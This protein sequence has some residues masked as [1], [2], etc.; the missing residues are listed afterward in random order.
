MNRSR[1][2]PVLHSPRSRVFAALLS[3]LWLAVSLSCASAQEYDAGLRLGTEWFQWEE[4]SRSGDSLLTEEGPRFTVG[5]YWGNELKVQQGAYYLGEADLYLGRVDYDGETIE[6]GEAVNTETDYLGLR[7]EFW[8]GY[9]FSG[10]GAEGMSFDLM[11]SLGMDRW[12]RSLADSRLDDGTQVVGYD[13]VYTILYGRIGAGLFA[14]SGD[15]RGRLF[16]GLKRPLLTDE[17]A[18]LSEIG[19]SNDLN[20]EPEGRNSWFVGFDNRFALDS[21]REMRLNLYYDSYRFDES[22]YDISTCP[23]SPPGAYVQPES[24][25]DTIGVELGLTF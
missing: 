13:E 9:R 21:G 8:A 20:L 7:G 1:H 17:V 16:G 25:M 24:H 6:S 22:D 12:L 15:W 18:E 19:C 4:F 10:P 11:G 3:G 2:V 23:G 5:G 14:R